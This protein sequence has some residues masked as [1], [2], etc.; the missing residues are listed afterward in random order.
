MRYDYEIG[1]RLTSGAYKAGV[2][3]CAG[4]DDDQEAFVQDEIKLLISDAGFQPIDAIIAATLNGAKALHIADTHG[5]I[6]PGKMADLLVLDK[7]PLTNINNI[8]SVYLV[9]KRG[10]L[11]KK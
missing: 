9:I 1:R 8:A 10:L 2:T 4:T 3:I 11:F 5:T 6:S 7:D